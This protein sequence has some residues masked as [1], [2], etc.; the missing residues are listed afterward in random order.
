M[1]RFIRIRWS[2]FRFLSN[3]SLFSYPEFNFVSFL[4][5]KKMYT[6]EENELELENSQENV[7]DVEPSNDNGYLHKIQPFSPVNNIFSLGHKVAD[8]KTSF[9]LSL[10][11]YFPKT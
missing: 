10:P 7:V 8:K 3:L 6:D 4:L 9:F 1:I 11:S 5:E 2:V